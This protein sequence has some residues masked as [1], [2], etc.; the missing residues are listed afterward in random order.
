MEKKVYLAIIVVVVLLIVGACSYYLIFGKSQNRQISELSENE[1]KM[2]NSLN[3]HSLECIYSCPV[4]DVE[5]NGLSGERWEQNCSAACFNKM[6]SEY[7][8]Q[9]DLGFSLNPGDE[10]YYEPKMMLF[11][12]DVK[13]CRFSNKTLADEALCIKNVLPLLKEKYHIED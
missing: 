10:E 1:I 4:V 8:K 7:P 12:G 11:S 2:L 6:K 13:N 5:V 9:Y 3:Y